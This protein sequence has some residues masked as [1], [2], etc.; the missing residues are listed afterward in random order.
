M[1]L[2]QKCNEHGFNFIS[3]TDRDYPPTSGSQTM[4]SAKCPLAHCME[5]IRLKEQFDAL[6]ATVD[7][8]RPRLLR[9]F[10]TA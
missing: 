5:G 9:R 3:L 4:F 8:N 10:R 1:I 6:P 7:D 2:E